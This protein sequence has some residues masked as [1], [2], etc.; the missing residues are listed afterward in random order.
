[1][2][3]PQA[4]E[5]RERFRKEFKNWLVGQFGEKRNF[6]VDAKDKR[7]YDPKKD[8]HKG[9]FCGRWN[10]P[11]YEII[12]LNSGDRMATLK[13]N[14][15]AVINSE[16]P[17]FDENYNLFKDKWGDKCLFIDHNL[18]TLIEMPGVNN[19]HVYFGSR[20][21]Q[22]DTS[23]MSISLPNTI[24]LDMN[25][26]GYVPSIRPYHGNND[27][28]LNAEIDYTKSTSKEIKAKLPVNIKDFEDCYLKRD[29]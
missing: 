18:D 17:E 11:S 3:S 14:G 24:N 22:Q 23:S 16:S 25:R 13:L 7:V 4:A 9:L 1:M 21:V 2:I 8:S 27:F 20:K 15:S 12:D 5:E 28:I 19:P 10:Q 6:L 29:N 26:M